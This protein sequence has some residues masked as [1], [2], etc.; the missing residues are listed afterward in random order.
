LTSSSSSSSV[1]SIFS[2]APTHE[3]ATAMSPEMQRTSLD[4]DPE[5]K[6]LLTLIDRDSASTTSR[7]APRANRAQTTKRPVRKTIV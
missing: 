1:S 6:M 2:S 5:A 3:R 7:S 4:E